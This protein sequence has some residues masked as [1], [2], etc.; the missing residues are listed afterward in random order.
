MVILIHVV[1]ALISIIQ[2]TNLLLAPSKI[3]LYSTYALFA[4]TLISG[5]YL[6][7]AMPVHILTTCIEGIIYMG[8][9]LWTIILVSSKLAKKTTQD[10]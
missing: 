8:F 7:I 6:I 1:I 5:T 9:V 4:A 2:T 3:K 10:A